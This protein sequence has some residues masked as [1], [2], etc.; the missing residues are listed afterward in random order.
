LIAT[1]SGEIRTISDLRPPIADD[2]RELIWD[3][4]EYIDLTLRWPGMIQTIRAVKTLGV[5]SRLA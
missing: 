5:L 2:L 3:A 4:I 1:G